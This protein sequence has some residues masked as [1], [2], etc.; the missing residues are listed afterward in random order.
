[1][2]QAITKVRSVKA[3][4]FASTVWP[5]ES[6]SLPSFSELYSVA[7]SP[8]VEK[9]TID[10]RRTL[11]KNPELM[12]NEKETSALVCDTLTSLGIRHSTGWGVNTRQEHFP[13]PGGFG[14]VAEIGDG[15]GPCI[16][17]RADMDALP[18][19]EE[20]AVPFQSQVQGKMHACGHDAH[21]SM[22]LGAAR[23]LAGL[24]QESRLPPGTVRLVFQPA[25]EGGAG[26]KRMVEEGVLSQLPKVER[27]FGMHLWPTLPSGEIGGRAGP[28]MSASEK[29]DLVVKGVGGHAAMPHL[30]VDPVVCSAALVGQ[31]QSLVSRETSPL[32]SAVVSVTKF[33]AGHAYNVIPSEVHLGGTIRCLSEGNLGN[34]KSS[35]ERVARSTAEAHGCAV[36]SLSFAPDYY[37]PTVNDPELWNEFVKPTAAKA[38]L[39]SHSRGENSVTEV[40]PSLAGEDFSFFAREVPSAFLFIG[41]GGLPKEDA[42]G[43]DSDEQQRSS[44]F[45]RA[46]EDDG[47]SG[48]LNTAYP[49]HH[50]CFAVDE[51]VLARG[52][53]L[54]AFL[55]TQSLG[56]LLQ[57]QQQRQA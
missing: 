20:T 56:D 6:A 39:Y 48:R 36:T 49:L 27:A 12:Y 5:H 7:S 9:W 55:A 51:S 43:G 50:P 3:R 8:E 1:M 37:P 16:L 13:G 24:Q 23:L 46:P 34:L 18:L 47:S 40:E 52:A 33:N 4:G 19:D 53:A 45:S 25:E 21:T 26:A 29:F 31:L 30:A 41:Q 54:H 35:L 32:D 28:I 22:L 11:H 38:V 2:K 42:K 15:Q 17:L 44:S 14:V 10:L 57:K